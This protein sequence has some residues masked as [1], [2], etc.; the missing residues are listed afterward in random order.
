MKVSVIITTF[1]RP[2]ALKEA[3]ESVLNQSLLPFEIVVVNDGEELP[4][5]EKHLSHPLVRVVQNETSR[6]ANFSRNKGAKLAAGDILMFL[7]DDDTWEFDKILVQVFQFEKRPEV[8]LVYTGKRMVYD[9]NRSK[10][11]YRVAADKSGNLFPEILKKN[12]IGTTSAVAL[13]KKVFFEAGGFDEE[14]PAMQDYD[15]WIRVCQLGPAIGDGKY[16]VRYTLNQYPKNSQISNS[17][18]NQEIAGNLILEK[19]FHLYKQEGISLRKRKA[20][21]YFYI[22]KAYRGR[23]MKSA[24]CFA[25]KSFLTF[26]NLPSL[27][28]VLFKDFKRNK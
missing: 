12:I 14:F 5:S 27:A 19:Y 22:A 1:N 2:Q 9:T 10:E 20:R 25:A 21:M 26:P 6:G 7:D 28:V 24:L 17:G 18:K 8:G 11:I 13:R 16:N 23:H 15:L 4:V 3:V